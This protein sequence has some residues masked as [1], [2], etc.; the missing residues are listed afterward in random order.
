MMRESEDGHSTRRLRQFGASQWA[1]WILLLSV[2]LS[3]CESSRDLSSSNSIVGQSREEIRILTSAT[4][5]L[6]KTQLDSGHAAYGKANC[7]G[8]HGSFHNSGYASPDCARCHGPNGAPSAPAEHYNANCTLCHENSHPKLSRRAPQDCSSCH[9]PVE[10][11]KVCLGVGAYDTVV[12]GA[13][14]GGLA[15]AASLAKAGQ[16]VMIIERSD[17][18]GGYMTAF[19]RGDYRFDASLHGF[20]GLDSTVGIN[21]DL[22]ANLGIAT[23]VQTSRIS[24]VLYRVTVGDQ[25]MEIPANLDEFRDALSKRFPRDKAG[26]EKLFQDMQDLGRLTAKAMRSERGWFGYPT[27]LWP[28]E[29]QRLRNVA[30]KRFDAF[31]EDYIQDPLAAEFASPLAWFTAVAP[32]ELSALAGVVV[33]D[34]Y[35]AGG[36]YYPAGGSESLSKAM[37]EVIVENGGTIKLGTPVTQI[38][39]SDGKATEVRTDDGGCYRAKNVVSNASATATLDL[40][41]RQN[42]PADYVSKVERMRKS[43]SAFVIYLGLNHDY[44]ADFGTSPAMLVLPPGGLREAFEAAKAC[45]LSKMSM[46]VVNHTMLDPTSAPAGKS[47]LMMMTLVDDQCFD[48]WGWANGP[49]AYQ[50]TKENVVLHFLEKM[51]EV[52]PGLTRHID[53]LETGTPMT[54][55]NYTG[56]SGGQFMGWAYTPDQS[57]E[58]RLAQQTPIKN[59]Y[60][61]GAWTSPGGGQSG[62]MISGL[63]AAKL[64]LSKD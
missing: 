33:L 11:P 63:N 30:S 51:S 52:L 20:D 45:D 4:P 32:K 44:R 35:H 6:L 19:R 27:D 13:G 54:M 2:V 40:I 9:R 22:F 62:V 49:A 53:V 42:L 58:K 29:V 38:V 10:A 36:F 43:S 18:V 28:W 61:A 5:A 8:C 37:A 47:V 57:W 46:S 14:G 23:K 25:T 1:P 12:V 60:L 48:G 39:V 26:F 34:S 21:R 56:N 17:K 50:Q 3:G 24:P 41:G 15:A 7:T 55:Q 16:K 31:L 64:I 59:V